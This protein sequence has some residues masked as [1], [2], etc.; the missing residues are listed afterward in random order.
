MKGCIIILSVLLVMACKQN[1]MEPPQTILP[2]SVMIDMIVDAFVLNAAYAET[3]GPVRDSVS[4]VFTEQLFRHHNVP[5]E[6]F[7][8]NMEWLNLHPEK[9]DILYD[10]VL[11][12]LDTLEDKVNADRY[13]Q[14]NQD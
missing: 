7:V 8:E 4:D 5:E 1:Q 2:D 10:R 12:K 14:R 13:Q 9:L 6:V 3:F 11:E